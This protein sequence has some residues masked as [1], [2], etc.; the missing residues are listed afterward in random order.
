[1]RRKRI[2]KYNKSAAK[3]IERNTDDNYVKKNPKR[4][5]GKDKKTGNNNRAQNKRRNFKSKMQMAQ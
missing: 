1:M 3:E 5:R 4:A 2:R